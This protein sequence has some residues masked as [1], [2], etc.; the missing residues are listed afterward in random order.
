MF[1]VFC[2]CGRQFVNS[3][4]AVCRRDSPLGLD[5][6][7]FEKTLQG[8][9]QRPFFNLKQIMRSSF[10]VLYERVA[11]RRLSSQG[12][13]NHHLQSARKEVSLWGFLHANGSFSVSAKAI[14]I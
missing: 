10:D 3:N 7:F 13:E 9:I 1:Q 2:A 4:A 11:V 14:L 8:W 12:L 6:F 5:Q